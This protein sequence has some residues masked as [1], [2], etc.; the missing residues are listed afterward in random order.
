MQQVD[1]H[2]VVPERSGELPTVSPA[3]AGRPSQHAY[4]AASRVVGPPNWGALQVTP[5]LPSLSPSLHRRCSAVLSAT[6]VPRYVG[7]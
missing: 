1:K 7:V 4:L 2:E 6:H 5:L 3:V